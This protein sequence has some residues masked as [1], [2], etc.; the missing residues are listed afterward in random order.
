MSPSYTRA[1]AQRSLSARAECVCA[2]RA[3]NARTTVANCLRGACARCARE[4]VR[5]SSPARAICGATLLLTARVLHR[6]DTHTRTYIVHTHVEP[7]LCCGDI[8]CCSNMV[9]CASAA[10]TNTQLCASP[11]KYSDNVLFARTPRW[12]RGFFVCF[13]NGQWSRFR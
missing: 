12:A 6:H 7:I 13:R 9:L 4:S 10:R 1:L 2:V 3:H 11:G 5:F 8:N